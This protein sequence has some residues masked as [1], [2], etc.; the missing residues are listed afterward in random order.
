MQVQVAGGAN[1]KRACVATEKVDGAAGSRS[2]PQEE[3]VAGPDILP[4]QPNGNKVKPAS[5]RII[6]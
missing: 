6:Q 1:V 3:T 5:A 4:P 2:R